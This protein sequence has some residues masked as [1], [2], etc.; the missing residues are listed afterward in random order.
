MTLGGS[1]GRVRRGPR[2]LRLVLPVATTPGNP[3]T[4]APNSRS[5]TLRY[6]ARR[7]ASAMY[8]VITQPFVEGAAG[9][10]GRN[11][12][13]YTAAGLALSAVTRKPES[14]KGKAQGV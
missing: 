9:R 6:R 8:L 4:V 5:S 14:R 3:V 7:R 11:C 2:A 10:L 12:E 1:A 13:R